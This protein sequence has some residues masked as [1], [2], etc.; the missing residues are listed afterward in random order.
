MFRALGHVLGTGDSVVTIALQ[1]A[2]CATVLAAF[3]FTVGTAVE[4]QSVTMEVD[5]LVEAMVGSIA[6]S[7]P[8]DR[9][10]E[11]ATRIR[12]QLPGVRTQL[13]HED[14]VTRRQNRT[15]RDRARD[16][17]LQRV[18]LPVGASAVIVLY[19]LF[20]PPRCMLLCAHVVHRKQPVVHVPL[21]S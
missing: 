10:R 14:D 21:P 3:Y 6:G 9:R 7:I 20:A 16:F 17:L 19:S 5:E 8:S 1:V 4:H 18:Y 15:V 2:V 11:I 12:Q 13:R